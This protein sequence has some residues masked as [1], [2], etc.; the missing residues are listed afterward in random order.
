MTTRERVARWLS[1]IVA[2]E[3]ALLIVYQL[4]EVWYPLQGVSEY[5][6]LFFGVT[7]S[8]TLLIS[9]QELLAREPPRSRGRHHGRLLLLW[10]ALGAGLFGPIYLWL[11]IEHLET[12]AGLLNPLD[13]A[14]G[15][16]ALGGVIVAGIFT[17]GLLLTSITCLSLAYFFF[18]DLVPGFLG[19]VPYTTGFI[20]TYTTLHPVNGIYNLIPLTAD[21]I[22]YVLLFSSV[23]A[24]TGAV[25]ALLELGKVF[26]RRI[27]GG[28]AYPAVVGSALVGTMVGQ[29]VAN[30]VITGRITIPQMKRQGFKPEMA[31]AVETS[32]SAGSLIMPP[33]MGLGAFV[34]AYFMNVPYIKVALAAAIPA[35]LYYAAVGLGVY[36]YARTRQMERVRDPVDWRLVL[37]VVPTFIV[38]LGVLTTLLLLMYT[39]KLAG[40]W[41]LL[42]TA[43]APFLVQGRYRPRF[44]ALWDGLLDGAKTA[45][46]MGF[47]LAL[48]GPVAQTAI[49]TGLGASFSNALILSPFG[50]TPLLA[51][52]LVALATLATGAAVPEAATYMI[53]AV[54][55]APFLEEVGFP[56]L[57]AHMFVFYYSVFATISPPI[58]ITASAAAQLAGASFMKTTWLAQKLAFVGL[59]VPFVFMFNPV[60][61]AFPTLSVDLVL[62]LAATLASLVAL[63]A[64]WWAWLGSP[65]RWHERG[66]VGVGGL[67][68]LA[69]A[70]AGRGEFIGAGVVLAGLAAMGQWRK[71]R[72]K[73]GAAIGALEKR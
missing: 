40:F 17:W 35:V 45:A 50:D 23:L 69:W 22:F 24:K 27:S 56:R 13:I 26:G 65:L 16:I 7:F 55:L 49:T 37:R 70:A 41:A 4:I 12:S 6:S 32:A 18:G 68:F 8:M 38:S 61:L 46:Q 72:R 43:V 2:V 30:V 10:L 51:L 9:I 47:L 25:D 29:A 14:V 54:V 67:A 44:R 28:A 15:F 66:M 19:H 42:T 53:M 39:P 48:I 59:I 58:A 52:P 63:S 31:A 1:G 11:N 62:T 34:M 71:A 60:L 3:A 21:V 73:T 20:L 36:F 33:I 5:Y 64:A 57:A